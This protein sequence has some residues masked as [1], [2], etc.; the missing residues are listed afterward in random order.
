MFVCTERKNNLCAKRES[1]ISRNPS[2]ILFEKMFM[3]SIMKIGFP[4]TVHK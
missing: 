2:Q 4:K 1:A 3:L